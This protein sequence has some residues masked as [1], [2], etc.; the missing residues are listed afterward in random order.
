[1]KSGLSELGYTLIEMLVAIS[2]STL[3]ILAIGQFATSSVLS[4][5][6]DY[7]QTLVLANT[8]E[9]VG[10]VA[11]QIRFGKSVLAKNVLP[12]TY[13]PNAPTDYF[14]WAS[15]AGSGNPLVL[16]VP[17]RASDGSVIYDGSHVI[18]TDNVIFYLDSTT[19]RLYKRTLKNTS[20]TGNVAVTTCPPAHATGSCPADAIV[21]DDVANLA[22]NYLKADGT[23]TSTPANTEAVTY[24][25]TE[26]RTIQ[27]HAYTGTYTT[28]ATLRN[29]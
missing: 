24:T 21:V 16:A 29:R 14:S 9:A 7:N 17:S 20:A 5:N 12:D 26:T 13:A 8:K 3:L 15:T 23:T 4:T 25:V 19:H 27:G 1:V 28:V 2:M 10:I 6:Q 18:Y 22:T 11:R